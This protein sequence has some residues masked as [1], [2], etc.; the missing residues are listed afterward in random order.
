M[1]EVEKSR[2]KKEANITATNTV[3]NNPIRPSSTFPIQFLS[4]FLP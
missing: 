1:N 2:K 4:P 3:L